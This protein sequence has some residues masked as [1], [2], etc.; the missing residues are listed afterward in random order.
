MN[1]SVLIVEDEKA[2]LEVQQELLKLAS[3]DVFT[4]TTLGDAMRIL[5]TQK[6]DVLF[7][8]IRLGN[9]SG[10]DLAYI[11]QTLYPNLAVVLTTGYSSALRDNVI[12]W[13]V[14]TKPYLNEDCVTAL[15]EAVARVRTRED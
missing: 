13:P 6:I 3:F 5:S 15:N 14:L 11:A 4:A 8:D 2:I 10:L 1:T 12:C 7:A 9:E